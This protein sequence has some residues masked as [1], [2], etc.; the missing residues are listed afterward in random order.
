MQGEETLPDARR[1]QLQ[2]WIQVA[3][4]S[5]SVPLVL[6]HLLLLLVLLLPP[7]AVLVDLCVYVSAALLAGQPAWQRQSPAREI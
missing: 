5:K 6:L 7:F 4:D 1:P 3:K 2:R